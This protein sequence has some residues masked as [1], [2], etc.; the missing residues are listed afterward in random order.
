MNKLD[1]LR[2]LYPHNQSE[3]SYF[4]IHSNKN[5]NFCQKKKMDW[6]HAWLNHF[7]QFLQSKTLLKLV[8]TI[9]FRCFE[10]RTKITSIKMFWFRTNSNDEIFS[11]KVLEWIVRF[12][13]TITVSNLVNKWILIQVSMVW[14]SNENEIAAN[15]SNQKMIE[16]LK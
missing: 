8:I 4:I 10:M 1:I 2:I 6:N 7:A 9:Y 15:R 13:N 3:H 16:E 12:C 5:I 11:F 14:Y